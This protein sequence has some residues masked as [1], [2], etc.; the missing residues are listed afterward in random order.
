MEPL[1]R[2]A[3]Q[4]RELVA[5]DHDLGLARDITVAAHEDPEHGTEGEVEEAKG[6]PRIL[7][8]SPRNA[9]Q[10]R[11]PSIGTLHPGLS[12]ERETYS[13]AGAV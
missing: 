10:S 12:S 1:T 7:T 2:R 8:N 13:V 5:Q 3:A 9:L 11:D 6:H 4:H